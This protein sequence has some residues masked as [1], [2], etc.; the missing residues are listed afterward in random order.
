MVKFEFSKKT[1]KKD[2]YKQAIDDYKDLKDLM[3]LDKYSFDKLDKMVELR[4]C[5]KGEYDFDWNSLTITIEKKDN[6][7]KIKIIRIYDLNTCD[8]LCYMKI[9]GE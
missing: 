9:K 4:Y 3:E 7:Y 2:I 8:F 5:D 1:F 6:T